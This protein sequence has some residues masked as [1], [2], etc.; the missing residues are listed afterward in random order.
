MRDGNI[1]SAL[2]LLN[3]E[4]WFHLSGCEKPQ[5]NRFIMLIHESPLRDM[6]VDVWC[7]MGAVRII[8][9]ILKSVNSHR[10]VTF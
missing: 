10:Y 6:K 5:S 4:A 8:G 3:W 9:L 7:A 2:V 1:N